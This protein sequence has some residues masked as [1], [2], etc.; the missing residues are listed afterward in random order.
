[1]PAQIDD[2][3]DKVPDFPEPGILFYDISPLLA[4]PTVWE[5]VIDEIANIVAPFRPNFLAAIDSRGFL[6]ASPLAL[7]IGCGIILIRKQGKLPGTTAKQ[8]YSLEY[9]KD[10]LELR[11]GIIKP[12][13]K[14]FILD[15]LLAT[16]GTAEAAVK[17]ISGVGAQVV[18]A[19]F[20]VELDG[21]GGRGRLQNI[22]C[23]SLITYSA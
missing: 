15:D 9:G 5:E 21:L 6:I 17:L 16:G 4:T 10:S 7:K 2:Y 12:G 13:D 14:I 1:M 23:K 18:G 8:E 20:L 3:I 22:P 19:A 11:D